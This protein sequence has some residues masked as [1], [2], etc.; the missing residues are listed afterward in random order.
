VCIRTGLDG[1]A[2]YPYT[3]QDGQCDP[4]RSARA[5]ATIDS[6]AD[7]PGGSEAQLA[8]AVGKGPVSV[9]IEADQ[10][11]FQVVHSTLR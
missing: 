2:D 8:V 3:A 10:S 11:G 9:A 4:A 5:A 6:W 1:E 7:V